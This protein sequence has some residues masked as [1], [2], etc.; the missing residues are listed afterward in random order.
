MARKNKVVSTM[1]TVLDPNSN[2]TLA[3]TDFEKDIAAKNQSIRDEIAKHDPGSAIMSE[4]EFLAVES[5]IEQ[6]TLEAKELITQSKNATYAPSQL[7]SHSVD[8]KIQYNKDMLQ[9][10]INDWQRAGIYSDELQTKTEELSQS[11]GNIKEHKDF[12]KYLEGL[13]EARALAKLATQDKRSEEERQRALN[14]EYNEYIKL[15]KERDAIEAKM[16]GLDNEKNKDELA[17]LWA[18]YDIK[19]NEINDKY[20][21]FISRPDVQEYFSIEDLARADDAARR[22]MAVKEGRISDKQRLEEEAAA[23][24]KVNEAYQ[25]YIRLVQE[26]G[27]AGVRLAGLDP[28]KHKEQINE[29]TSYIDNIDTELN[30]TY[31]NLLS[32]H[33]A[34]A[35]LTL[36]DFMKYYDKWQQKLSEKEAQA[37]DKAR[38]KEELPYRNYGKTIANSTKRKQDT[39]V[40]AIDSIGV[41]DKK[42]LDQ[43]DD[44]NE[45]VKEVLNI[46]DQFAKD[47]KAAQDDKLVKK[48]QKYSYEAEQLRK[49]IKA[50]V[51]EEQRISNISEEQGFDPFQLLPG[52]AENITILKN[53]MESFARSG[54]KGRLEIKGWND[55][56]TKLYY[57]VTDS[58]GAVQEMTV[59]LGQGTNQLYK[60]RT[61]TKETGT[62]MQQIFKGVRVKAKELI[63]Y[64][65][66]GGSVYKVIEM[67]RQGV[68]YV[69][70]IDLALTELKKVTNETE[71]TYRKF[72]DTAAK[73]AAK[74]GS[75]IKD[76]VSSTADWARLNI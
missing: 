50:V 21:D 67:L 61:A 69:R 9:S 1:S 34:Q 51:D 63:S 76:V 48:F 39:L 12:K 73:T 19:D 44:Y 8:S 70:E 58:K 6:L 55:D 4:E 60:M 5:R 59:A 38:N 18:D 74:V 7:E 47:P 52:Q 13:K 14:A 24:L 49:S 31:G 32:N 10:Y 20:G 16:I 42:V 28:E 75:T 36:E 57:S 26:R 71:K 53:E 66:G 23:Q 30:E 25:E 11:L 54:A 62:L 27:R 2:K 68:Q 35:T 15:I 22:K 65:I 17:A 45:K 40:G 64:V 33:I 37:A 43:I 72:L 29:L 41:T 56:N 46:R 3:G